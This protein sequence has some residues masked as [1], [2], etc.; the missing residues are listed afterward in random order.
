MCTMVSFIDDFSRNT[1]IY[2]LKG[3]NEVFSK[4]KEYKALFENQ[5]ER[6][7]NT[8]HSDNGGEFTSKEF[9]ELYREYGI[10]RE[11]ST[12]YNP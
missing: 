3:K 7:I 1:W 6:N 2:F 9:E 4:F 11:L 8:L 10:K 5:N 12:P